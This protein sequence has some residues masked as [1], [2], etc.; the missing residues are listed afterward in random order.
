MR[1]PD[2]STDS[3]F[4]IIAG[5]ALRFLD[6]KRII[7]NKFA[8]DPMMDAD[9]TNTKGTMGSMLLMNAKKTVVKAGT[10]KAVNVKS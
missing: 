5:V 2:K 7:V 10:M 1:I 8:E 3:Q 9:A 4:I 6:R